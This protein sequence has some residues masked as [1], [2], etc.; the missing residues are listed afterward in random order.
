M[1][2]NDKIDY[3]YKLLNNI[4]SIHANHLYQLHDQDCIC[5]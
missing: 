1:Y 3:K 5:V 2:N 4:T